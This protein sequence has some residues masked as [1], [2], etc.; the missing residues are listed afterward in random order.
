MN[1][2]PRQSTSEIA[3]LGVL[4]LQ[5]GLSGYDIRE[6]IGASISHFWNESFGQ[7]YPILAKLKRQKLVTVAVDKGSPRDR[8]LYSITESGRQKVR[9]WIA[10][11]AQPDRP[12]SEML[13]K[14]FLGSQTEPNVVIEHLESLAESC[15]AQAIAFQQIEREVRRQDS[16]KNTLPYSI[17]SIRAGLR[18]AQARAKWA[19]EAIEI[20]QEGVE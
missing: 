2:Q 20:I 17:A 4:S 10:E 15:A 3:I 9:E 19:R 6:F 5:D 12:R 8:K 7:I 1:H 14:V 18:L 13:L 16:G 11:K